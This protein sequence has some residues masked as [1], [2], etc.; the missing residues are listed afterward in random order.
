MLLSLFKK[1]N[2]PQIIIEEDERLITIPTKDGPVFAKQILKIDGDTV[3]YVDRSGTVR[4]AVIYRK[5][6]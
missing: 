1:K 2:K 5:Q 4:E 6:A 3:V